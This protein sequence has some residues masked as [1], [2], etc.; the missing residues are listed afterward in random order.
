MRVAQLRH[1]PWGAGQF[2]FFFKLDGDPGCDPGDTV[3]VTGHSQGLAALANVSGHELSETV[4]DPRDGG[5]WDRSGAENAD[6]CAWTFHGTVTIGGEQWMIRELTT[7]PTTRSGYDHAGCIQEL[8]TGHL[9][10]G[11]GELNPAADGW[12]RPSR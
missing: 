4:T 3:T 5:W 8:G 9:R 1:R 2:G 10:P 6:K 12:R 7:R 11:S